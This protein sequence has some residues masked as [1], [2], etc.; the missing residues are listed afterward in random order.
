[1]ASRDSGD[2][3]DYTARRVAG[4]PRRPARRGLLEGKAAANVIA[5]GTEARGLMSAE[6]SNQMTMIRTVNITDTAL[7]AVVHNRRL[8][9][10]MIWVEARTAITQVTDVIRGAVGLSGGVLAVGGDPSDNVKQERLGSRAW[11]FVSCAGCDLGNMRW[12]VGHGSERWG[13]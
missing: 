7:A 1:M 9:A 10:Q 2:D 12:L 11:R 13:R 3:T 5:E 8:S 4:R 6:G